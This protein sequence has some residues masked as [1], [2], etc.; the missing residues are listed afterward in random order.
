MAFIQD[1][2]AWGQAEPTQQECLQAL[3]H[4]INLA[5]AEL[6]RGDSLPMK[7]NRDGF[8]KEVAEQIFILIRAFGAD[9]SD[10]DADEIPLYNNEIWDNLVKGWKQRRDEYVEE[11]NQKLQEDEVSDGQET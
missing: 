3:Q 7:F 5:D 4:L 9:P 11:Q 6:A 8:L 10:F 2:R 1:K